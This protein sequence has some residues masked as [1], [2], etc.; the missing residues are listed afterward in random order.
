ML[1]DCAVL[2]SNLPE[3]DLAALRAAD[4]GAAPAKLA[5][6]R[7]VRAQQFLARQRGVVEQHARWVED[8]LTRLAPKRKITP[9]NV[10][11]QFYD[12]LLN[13]AQRRTSARERA[14][15]EKDAKEEAALKMSALL[16]KQGKRH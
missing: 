9:K 10:R 2:L 1:L 15:N 16:A 5:F 6:F 12:R 11:D 4:K 3:A 14:L 7:A 13:D 8:E